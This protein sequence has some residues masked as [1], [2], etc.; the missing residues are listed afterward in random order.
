MLK[1]L[2]KDNK[3]QAL[4]ELALILPVLLLLIFGIIEFGRVFGTYLMVTHG[5]RE[6]ARAAAVGVVDMEVIT[7]IENRTAGLHLN[8]DKLIVNI[9]PG[10]LNRS[11]GDGVTVQV[12]YPVEINAPFISIFTGNLYTVSSQVT[13][14]IE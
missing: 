8:K 3:G 2:K 9:T 14:R 1:K 10:V 13:M 5:A 7:L 6:G 11:R 4:V 12:E